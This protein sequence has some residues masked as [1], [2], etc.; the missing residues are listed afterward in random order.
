[1][2]ALKIHIH[3]VNPTCAVAHFWY[4]SVL[5]NKFCGGLS[6]PRSADSPVPGNAAATLILREVCSIE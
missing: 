5:L 2:P 3:L 6:I 1:M 4:N